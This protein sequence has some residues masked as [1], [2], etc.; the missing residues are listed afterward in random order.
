MNIDSKLEFTRILTNK[1]PIDGRFNIVKG[2]GD[3]VTELFVVGVAQVK[4][5]NDGSVAQEI[6]MVLPYREVVSFILNVREI[7]N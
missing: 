3:L 6:D 1:G 5:D 4:Q 2:S 7:N